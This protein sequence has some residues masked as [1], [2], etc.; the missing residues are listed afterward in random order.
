MRMHSS[1]DTADCSWV[2]RSCHLHQA[3][4]T[5][6]GVNPLNHAFSKV[7]GVNA[8]VHEPLQLSFCVTVVTVVDIV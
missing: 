7:S 6:A 2:V 3:A 1:L 5:P 4:K 8:V